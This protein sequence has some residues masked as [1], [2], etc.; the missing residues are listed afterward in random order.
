MHRQ[1]TFF[2]WKKKRNNLCI[3]HMEKP[4]QGGWQKLGWSCMKLYSGNGTMLFL[5]SLFYLFEE[6]LFPHHLLLQQ[7]AELCFS[8]SQMK[9]VAQF[10]LCQVRDRSGTQGMGPFKAAGSIPRC[11]SVLCAS[12]LGGSFFFF[13][14]LFFRS[15]HMQHS[16]KECL[17]FCC[18]Q[19]LCRIC[20]GAPSFAGIK[21]TG[22]LNTSAS[23]SPTPLNKCLFLKVIFPCVTVT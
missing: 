14:S 6:R 4:N 10:V 21:P 18:Q 5:Y 17:E 12:W 16:R 23:N 8:M 19:Q 3:N 15:V 20:T 1:C 11:L 9:L 7:L 22:Y 13:F 2:T